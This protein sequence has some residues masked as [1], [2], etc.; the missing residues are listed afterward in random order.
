MRLRRGWPW[1]LDGAPAGPSPV[2]PS[3][4]RQVAMEPGAC[5]HLVPTQLPLLHHVLGIQD[6]R[7][8]APAALSHFQ[9]LFWCFSQSALLMVHQPPSAC[10]PNLKGGSATAIYGGQSRTRTFRL[11]YHFRCTGPLKMQNGERWGGKWSALWKSRN[12]GEF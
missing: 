10:T 11:G 8:P 6:S 12:L 4:T 9:S 1:D 3:P 5:A 7:I 2:R